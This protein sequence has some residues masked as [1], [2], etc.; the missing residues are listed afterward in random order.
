M[1]GAN[2]RFMTKKAAWLTDHLILYAVAKGTT[3]CNPYSQGLGTVDAELDTYEFDLRKVGQIINAGGNGKMYE[4]QGMGESIGTGRNHQ[5]RKTSF[6]THPIKAYFLPWGT[7]M[8]FCGKLGND[9]DYFFTPTV[10]GCTFAYDGAAAN[11][12]VAHSNFVNNQLIDQAA[13]DN[14]L[15]AK[16]GHAPARTLIKAT[17]KQAPVP[18]VADDYRATVVGIR[19]A[20]GWSFYYQNYSVLLQPGRLVHTGI[21][22]CVPI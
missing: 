19:T 10:N 3:S 17:Y 12:S 21:N 20:N 8:T 9:A 7:G 15:L 4:L 16:F 22:L 2:Q 18:N 13:I 6:F 14:D 5:V 1:D 11:P